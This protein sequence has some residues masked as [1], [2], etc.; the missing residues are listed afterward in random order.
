[1][2]CARKVGVRELL[3]LLLED[4]DEGDADDAP[5]AL[6]VLDARPGSA[7]K[8][9]AGVDARGRRA[10]CVS[11]KSAIDL[12]RP[13][14][15]RSSPLSTKMQVSRSPMARWTS[16]AATVE[17]TP[18]ESA[19]TTR[20]SPTRS[21]MRGTQRVDEA[22]HRP[23]GLRRRRRGGRSCAGSRARRRCARPRDGTARRR[24][25]GRGGGR[26]RT[27]SC[28][29]WRAARGRRRARVTRSPWL[30]QTR[31]LR[32]P[33]DEQRID[34]RRCG[35]R[36]G[37]TPCARRGRRSPPNARLSTPMP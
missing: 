20:S 12:R 9:G 6:R 36:R 27:A 32:P 30:I 7:R 31:V 34:A 11:R 15:S 24:S 21:R 1:M 22:L 17:S 13:R 23:V 16:A 37:R 3:R 35:R 29:C 25:A 8:R 4:L 14:P 19:Q 2:P 10:P 18:P 33:I 26:P 5:L 28:R